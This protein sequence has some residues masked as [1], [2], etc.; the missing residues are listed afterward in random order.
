[1]ENKMKLASLYELLA[2]RLNLGFDFKGFYP[3]KS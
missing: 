3:V 2:Y 1:M